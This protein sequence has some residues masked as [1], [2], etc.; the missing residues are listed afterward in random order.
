MHPLEFVVVELPIYQ[1]TVGVSTTYLSK[2]NCV[3]VIQRK[4]LDKYILYF[5]RI[6]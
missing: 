1:S 6:I 4:S 3:K 5:G 2:V